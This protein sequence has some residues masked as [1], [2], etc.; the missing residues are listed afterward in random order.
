[1][2]LEDRGFSTPRS[3]RLKVSTFEYLQPERHFGHPSPAY[4][5]LGPILLKSSR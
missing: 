4:E 3:I 5:L 2:R 1:M